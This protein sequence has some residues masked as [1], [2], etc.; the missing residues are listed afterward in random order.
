[1]II[2]VRP[3]RSRTRSSAAGSL[4]GLCWDGSVV[5]PLQADAASHLERLLWSP[6]FQPL[7][8][9]E[10]ESWSLRPISDWLHFGCSRWQVCFFRMHQCC[11]DISKRKMF[12]IYPQLVPAHRQNCACKKAAKLIIVNMVSAAPVLLKKKVFF[13]KWGLTLGESRR[14]TGHRLWLR[15]LGSPLQA[16]CALNTRDKPDGHISDSDVV[17][18]T[19]ST[20]NKQPFVTERT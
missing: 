4:Q 11:C 12:T 16:S 3:V 2:K 19:K 10:S 5:G 1:M 6:G 13:D 20:K 17:C 9:R 7:R 14:N 15:L 18:W 8:E